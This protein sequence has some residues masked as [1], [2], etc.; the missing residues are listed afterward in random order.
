MKKLYTLLLAAAVALSATAATPFQ[1]KKAAMKTD[2]QFT[3]AGTMAPTSIDL[4]KLGLSRED[5]ATAVSR[6]ELPTLPEK[7]MLVSSPDT[8]YTTFDAAPCKIYED[9]TALG[10][11]S[12]LIDNFIM[13]DTKTIEAEINMETIGEGASAFEIP[14]LTIKA[15]TVLFEEN[16]VK[17][18]LRLFGYAEDEKGNIVPSIYKNNIEFIVLDDG[19]LTFAY[20]GNMGIAYVSPQMSG[21]WI[22]KPDLYPVNGSMTGVEGAPNAQSQMEYFEYSNDVWGQYSEEYKV[23]SLANF[24]DYGKLMLLDVDAANSTATAENQAV[25]DLYS[26][27]GVFQGYLSSV[28]NNVA[29]VTFSVSTENGKTVIA[30]NPSEPAYIVVN[31][32]DAFVMWRGLIESKI[33]LD[34]EIPGLSGISN[35]TVADENAPVEYYNLQGVRVENPANGL[36]IK[37]QGKTATKVFVK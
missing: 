17:Y 10:T 3:E 22:L 34:F 6:A 18:S 30:Q 2:I 19:S 14:I 5:V 23:I 27:S 33:T 1:H 11:G 28:G 37:R 20:D 24:A 13:S 9:P 15:N 7:F 4:K 25:V 16:G 21:S 8:L 29:P 12:Y 26:K 35:V 31:Q 32:N 36:Y